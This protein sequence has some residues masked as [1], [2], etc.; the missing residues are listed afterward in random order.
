[1]MEITQAEQ[2]L[3]IYFEAERISHFNIQL[4]FSSAIS[5]G[6]TIF[7][8]GFFHDYLLSYFIVIFFSFNIECYKIFVDFRMEMH[9][10]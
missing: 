8:H 9:H 4:H 1:M 10:S 7:P 6:Y 5:E 2:L 3:L